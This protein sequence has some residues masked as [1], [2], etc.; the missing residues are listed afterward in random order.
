MRF[1]YLM[2][3]THFLKCGKEKLK[4]WCV[5]RES[6]NPVGL[7]KMH[8][9]LAGLLHFVRNDGN[10]NPRHCNKTSAA[11]V[12]RQRPGRRGNT[13]S[14]VIAITSDLPACWL[15]TNHLATVLWLLSG[16]A[17]CFTSRLAITND[18]LSVFC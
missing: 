12:A 1:P 18:L 14:F 13:E 16:M 17:S 3:V 2:T 9:C 11:S 5:Y 10:L 15:I 6:W 7:T 8:P 4:N